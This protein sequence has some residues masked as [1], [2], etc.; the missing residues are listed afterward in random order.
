LSGGGVAVGDAG[1]AAAVALLGGSK[2][3]VDGRAADVQ[4]YD[5]ASAA[6]AGSTCGIR[7][8]LLQEELAAA[9]DEGVAKGEGRVEGQSGGGNG[10]PCMH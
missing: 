5:H 10:P 2:G 3:G 9:V 4:S 6:A 7:E 1:A 8:P